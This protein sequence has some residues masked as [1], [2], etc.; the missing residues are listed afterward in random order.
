[1]NKTTL[2]KSIKQ[3]VGVMRHSDGCYE[4]PL[5]GNLSLF[6]GWT[7]GYDPED[8]SCIHHPTDKDYCLNAGI[9]VNTSDSMKTDYEYINAPYYDSGDVWMTDCTVNP[10]ENY[11][12]LADYFLKEYEA[13]SKLEIDYDG[14]ILNCSSPEDYC[15]GLAE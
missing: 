1:M 11:N 9:K 13:M 14:Q 12:K 15:S 5:G 6:V 7:G 10:R 8:K 2:A 3:A 4:I